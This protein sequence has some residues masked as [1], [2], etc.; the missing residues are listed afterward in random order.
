MDRYV[1][2]WT[3]IKE[4]KD[5][6]YDFEKDVDQNVFIPLIKLYRGRT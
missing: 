4:I 2:S 3:N 5:K 6:I 1:S